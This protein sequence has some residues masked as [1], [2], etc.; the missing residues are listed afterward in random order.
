MAPPSL[1][2][3]LAA[4][5][6]VLCLAAGAGCSSWRGAQLYQ[7]GT[8]AL[9]RGDPA[10][11]VRDLEQAATLL[12]GASQVF[13][14]LGIAYTELARPEDALAAFQRAVV[15]DYDNL[16]A[17]ENLA[18]AEAL[19]APPGRLDGDTTPP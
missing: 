3:G 2:A 13:N 15:L 12:P 8:V 9:D 6:L 19:Q 17:S 1:R 10:A 4:L 5:A 14:H 11:A 18:V 16:A 7:S